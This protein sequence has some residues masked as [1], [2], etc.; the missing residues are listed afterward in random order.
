VGLVSS[1]DVDPV[2]AETFA[3]L[4]QIIVAE[5]GS[6]V[7]QEHDRLLQ[8]TTFTSFLPTVPSPTLAYAQQVEADGFHLMTSPSSNWSEMITGL[9]AT[10]V[11]A[12]VACVGDRVQ[13]GHPL[14]PVLQ[15]GR[16]SAENR[17]QRSDFDWMLS[18]TAKN[19]ARDILELLAKTLSQTY[20]P[21]THAN[22]NV[23]FQIT[24]GLFGVSL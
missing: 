1:G 18:S 24:R 3:S 5:G 13:Q 12:I 9:G 23:G 8:Q 6:I 4:S 7:V 22:A 10:G 2:S 14:I 11:A 16:D 19:N 15:V 17:L 20:V 21:S